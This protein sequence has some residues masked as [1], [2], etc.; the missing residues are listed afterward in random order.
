MGE[1]L[2]SHGWG[3][4]GR[5]YLTLIFSNKFLGITAFSCSLDCNLV[6]KIVGNQ[7]EKIKILKNYFFLF[8]PEKTLFKQTLHVFLL[9]PD[10]FPPI[11]QI[12][13]I[14][15]MTHQLS[16]YSYI[17]LS[18][19]LFSQTTFP[20]TTERLMLYLFVC[21]FS[22]SYINLNIS[23]SRVSDWIL[24]ILDASISQT[25]SPSNSKTEKIK[26]SGEKLFLGRLKC[27]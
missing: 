27:W 18:V 3:T 6:G 11:Y 1:H 2:Q 7:W 19:P 24:F 12:F 14:A 15:F 9:P 17:T 8:F 26:V 4:W 13:R 20:S 23:R 5:V 21:M 16:F 10:F 22:I 25:I